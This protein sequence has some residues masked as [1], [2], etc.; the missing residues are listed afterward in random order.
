MAVKIW[1]GNGRRVALLPLPAPV[2]AIAL[3]PW[4]PRAFCGDHVG[5]LVRVDLNGIEYG[6]I[7]VTAVE[8]KR[9]LAIRCPACWQEHDLESARLGS[10]L[11]CSTPEC[12]LSLRVN[13]FVLKPGRLSS[14]EGVS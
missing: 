7:I 9:G 6:P 11:M 13:S 12:G 10:V 14:T 3:H 4:Y 1:D 5:S 2:N 8:D